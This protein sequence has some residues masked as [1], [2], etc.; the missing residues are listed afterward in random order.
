VVRL[1]DIFSSYGVAIPSAPSDIPLGFPLGVPLLSLM[2]GCK[3]PYL[4]WSGAG[5]PLM[6]YLYHTSSS[7]CFLASSIQYCLG[8]VFAEGIV[9]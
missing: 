3:H 4:H 8:L 1:V 9:P 2:V 5:R 6:E 7:N